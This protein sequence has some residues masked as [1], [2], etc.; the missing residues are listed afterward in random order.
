M[1]GLLAASMT[2]GP[3]IQDLFSDGSLY[4]TIAILAFVETVFSAINSGSLDHGKHH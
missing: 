4:Q 1:N 2:L 3:S